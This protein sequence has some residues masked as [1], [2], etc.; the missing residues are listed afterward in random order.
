M[1]SSESVE[2]VK[3]NSQRDSASIPDVEKIEALDLFGSSED[4]RE[5]VRRPSV[6]SSVRPKHKFWQVTFNKTNAE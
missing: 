5:S 3:Q 6:I 1:D 2:F 4:I